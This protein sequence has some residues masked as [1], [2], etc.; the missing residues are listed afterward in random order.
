MDII[1]E[2]VSQE[3]MFHLS[4]EDCRCSSIRQV[5]EDIS[6]ENSKHNSLS[7]RPDRWWPGEPRKFSTNST[8]SS[9]GSAIL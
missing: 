3:E 2:A 6:E 8:A 4:P 5:G 9:L 7:K 1:S